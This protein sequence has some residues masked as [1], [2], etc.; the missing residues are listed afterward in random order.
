MWVSRVLDP[1]R[2]SHPFSVRCLIYYR[3]YSREIIREL[4]RFTPVNLPRVPWIVHRAD[5]VWIAPTFTWES[6]I[7]HTAIRV[8]YGNEQL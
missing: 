3:V 5:V 8:Q 7:T 6:H 4:P 2:L 1:Y